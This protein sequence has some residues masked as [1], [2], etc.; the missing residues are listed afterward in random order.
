MRRF[1]GRERVLQWRRFCGLVLCK[2][3][4]RDLQLFCDLMMPHRLIFAALLLLPVL[5]WAQD[6]SPGYQSGLLGQSNDLAKITRNGQLQDAGGILGDTS[7]KGVNPF[8][9]TDNQSTGLCFNTAPTRGQYHRLCF[10]HD[11]S[12]NAI[13]DIDGTDYPFST[14]I[15]TLTNALQFGSLGTL[16]PY[17]GTYAGQQT[18]AAGTAP[19]ANNAIRATGTSPLGSTL[20][21]TNL[22]PHGILNSASTAVLTANPWANDLTSDPGYGCVLGFPQ[23]SDIALGEETGTVTLCATANSAAPFLHV[24]GTFTP[25]QFTPT[26]PTTLPAGFPT[27]AV[28]IYSN[29]QPV[30][31]EALANATLNAFGQVTAWTVI[32]GGWYQQGTLSGSPP[33][34]AAGTP[35]GTA[36]YIGVQDKQWA[37]NIG[38]AMETLNVTGTITSGNQ[39][40][41]ISGASA[42]YLAPRQWLED[43]G[44]AGALAPH[45]RIVSVANDYSSITVAPPPIGNASVGEAL[46]F[47]VQP[48]N[49]GVVM[50]GDMRNGTGEAADTHTYQF[51]GTTTNGSRH[52]TGLST[53]APGGNTIYPGLNCKATAGWGTNIGQIEAINY[54]ASTLDLDIAATADATNATITCQARLD[55]GVAGLDVGGKSVSVPFVERGSPS[56]GFRG[57]GATDTYFFAGNGPDGGNTPVYGFRSEHSWSDVATDFAITDDLKGQVL[58]SWDGV[59]GILVDLNAHTLPASV[60]PNNTMLHLGAADSNVTSATLDGFGAASEVIFRSSHG[61]AISPTALTSSDQVGGLNFGGYDGNQWVTEGAQIAAVP[62]ATWTTASH[63]LDVYFQTTQIGSTS[64][65]TRMVIGNTGQLRLPAGTAPIAGSG[66]GGSPSVTGTDSFGTVTIGS[67]PS[68]SCT[69]TFGTAFGAVPNCFANDNTTNTAINVGSLTTAHFIINGSVVAGDKIAYLCIGA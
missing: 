37:S 59:N 10:G 36:A 39:T 6:R 67:A 57:M 13:F 32:G 15:G 56:Y 33:T 54:G 41:P 40:I 16:F 63:P 69:I 5:A 53:T 4:G 48:D 58:G 47:G 28:W 44:G 8:A 38:A 51:T 23:V 45:T 31:W 52:V 18:F 43:T 30:P 34:G 60:L 17:S 27:L 26:T 11:A 65:A 7:G 35:S 64:P 55:A 46:A 62:S 25:T 19:L 1:S 20:N 22:F 14:A 2:H 49:R 12:N 42:Q 29:D 50:E 61:T 24:P 3:G 9:V 21:L 68:T 66:C